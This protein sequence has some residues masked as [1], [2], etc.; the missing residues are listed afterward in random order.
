MSENW[1]NEALTFLREYRETG[2][3]DDLTLDRLLVASENVVTDKAVLDQLTEV[4]QII[5][6]KYVLDQKLSEQPPIRLTEGQL[7]EL[8]TLNLHLGNL[9]ESAA[10]SDFKHL[11]LDFAYTHRQRIYSLLEVV[12]LAAVDKTQKLHELGRMLREVDKITVRD[13]QLD[14]LKRELEDEIKRCESWKDKYIGLRKLDIRKREED[15][16]EEEESPI[17]ENSCLNYY[18]YSRKKEKYPF[19]SPEY[20]YFFKLPLLISEFF[21]G[22][23]LQI[24]LDELAKLRNYL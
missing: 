12:S 10:E 3:A 24:Q 6:W 14:R 21:A 13:A 22:C 2:D 16:D 7:A 23:Q 15:K 19:K 5:R 11:S 8:A 17:K 9:A 1:Q 20:S 4:H 18:C